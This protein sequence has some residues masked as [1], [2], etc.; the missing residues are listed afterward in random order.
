MLFLTLR[1][2]MAEEVAG[3]A[4]K[5]KM[6]R[7]RSRSP[8]PPKPPKR[9][10]EPNLSEDQKSD[11]AW[12]PDIW[13]PERNFTDE[14]HKSDDEERV[15]ASFYTP[16][17]DTIV[18]AFA[19]RGHLKAFLSIPQAILSHCPLFFVGPHA[20]SSNVSPTDEDIQC[21]GMAPPAK[22]RKGI[23]FKVI[24]ASL[25]CMAFGFLECQVSIAPD[26]TEQDLCATVDINRFAKYVASHEVDATIEIFRKK[27]DARV[28]VS[29]GSSCM[30]DNVF[31]PILDTGDPSKTSFALKLMVMKY[32]VEIKT[33][34]LQNV[35]K[36]ATLSEC[37]LLRIDVWANAATGG[38]YLLFK[39][40]GDTG[41]NCELSYKSMAHKPPDGDHPGDHPHVTCFS[42]MDEVVGPYSRV[43][44]DLSGYVQVYSDLFDAGN[45]KHF[46]AGVSSATTL[47]LIPA[48]EG[49][50]I[51]FTAPFGDNIGGAVGPSF[52]SQVQAP[53]MKEPDEDRSC[54]KFP[55]SKTR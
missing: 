28:C 8:K 40:K 31:I 15:A 12:E 27:G 24:D 9:S 48:E 49:K 29:G 35:A 7:V 10:P 4:K 17:A 42:I 44:E 1:F 23:S 46:V 25:A 19:S 43:A 41:D 37:S 55:Q 32:R 20:P 52:V 13:D 38:K 39:M 30:D 34:H 14:D 11:E 36:K 54:D 47:I 3:P 53:Q 22:Q 26:A 5:K 50:P 6:R 16:T 33:S 21:L 18:S 51:V 2:I 45:V